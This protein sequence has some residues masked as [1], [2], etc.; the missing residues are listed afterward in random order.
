MKILS[1]QRGQALIIQYALTFFV[2]VAFATAMTVYVRRALQARVHGAQNYVLAEAETVLV[3]PANN[4]VGNL[5][6]QYEPYYVKTSA[7]RS[8]QSEVEESMW[9]VGK[10]GLYGKIGNETTTVTDATSFQYPPVN[11]N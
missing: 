8:L 6:K 10:T 5:Y 4:L 2:V 9:P 7:K 11:A 1:N 3:D